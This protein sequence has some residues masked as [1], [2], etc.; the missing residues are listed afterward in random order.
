L[1]NPKEQIILHIGKYIKKKQNE[2]KNIPNDTGE[3]V[4]EEI[5]QNLREFLTYLEEKNIINT[6]KLGDN[7]EEMNNLIKDLMKLDLAKFSKPRGASKNKRGS[8]SPN[9]GEFQ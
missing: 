5:L 1:K 6:D 8:P 3:V 2:E 4:N 7:K 9:P